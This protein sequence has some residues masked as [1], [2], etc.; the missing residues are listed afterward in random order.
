MHKTV[1]LFKHKLNKSE[2]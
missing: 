1:N 2:T